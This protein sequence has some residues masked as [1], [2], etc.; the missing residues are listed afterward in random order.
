MPE[1][2]HDG[3]RL[4]I[5]LLGDFSPGDH[6]FTLGHGAGSLD[7]Q[8]RR[9]GLRPLAEVLGGCDWSV[10]NLEGVLGDYSPHTMPWESRFLRGEEDWASALAEA[11]VRAVSVANNHA[12]QHGER[13]FRNTV[14]ACRAAGL[15]VVGLAT[16]SGEVEPFEFSIGSTSAVVLA[17]SSVPDPRRLSAPTY[18]FADATTVA[19]Q[20][21][22]CAARGQL[23]IVVMHAGT[24]AA[25]LPDPAT[26]RAAATLR[27]A[28]ASV[29]A[30][31]HSHVFQPILVDDGGMTCCGLGDIF[32]DL[33]WHPAFVTSALV[34]VEFRDAKFESY[35]VLPMSLRSNP[36]RLE[37]LSGFERATFL[38]GLQER[39]DTLA[40]RAPD[41][42]PLVEYLAFRKLVFFLRH[43]GVGH[44]GD[45]FRFLRQK[46]IAR[47]P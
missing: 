13:G 1:K 42:A 6:Y 43:V 33:F 16:R 12:L 28:G 45:K 35:Q 5:G 41:S 25:W 11:G 34:T 46:L 2:P 37:A 47:L 20:V 21:T 23:V 10:V 44:T 19:K 26:L 4:R 14:A 15:S 3:E 27:Q 39:T 22:A 38:E 36:L 7:H 18:A 40:I 17:F 30:V 24:E 8:Q 31:H 29:V 9:D 32:M